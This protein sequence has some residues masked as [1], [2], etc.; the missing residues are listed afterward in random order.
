MEFAQMNALPYHGDAGRYAAMDVTQ[1]DRGAASV[2]PLL[3]GLGD[4]EPKEGCGGLSAGVWN[5]LGS[6]ERRRRQIAHR[7]EDG[8]ANRNALRS[9]NMITDAFAHLIREQSFSR[10]TVTEVMRRANLARNT[11]YA[12]YS[13]T[14]ELLKDFASVV[15]QRVRSNLREISPYADPRNPRTYLLLLMGR[16]DD[17]SRLLLERIFVPNDSNRRC[18]MA[19]I[20]NNSVPVLYEHVERTTGCSNESL[21][22]YVDFTSELTMTVI[23]DYLTHRLRGNEESTADRLAQI[24]EAAYGLYLEPDAAT[25]DVGEVG[26]EAAGTDASA[27]AD[28]DTKAR[29]MAA[30]TLGRESIAWMQ[31]DGSSRDQVSPPDW[32]D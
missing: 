32:F 16:V 4:D 5:S 17:D 29:G 21:R 26:G 13:S 23:S 11:F 20:R 1:P 7:K 2:F 27:G 24:Y 28:A 15:V 14:N 18:L 9:V 30:E 12:H 22:R 8:T 25:A 31:G 3:F 10:I 19:V 6:N